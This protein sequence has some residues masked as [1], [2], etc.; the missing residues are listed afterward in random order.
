MAAGGKRGLSPEQWA[1]VRKSYEA[2]DS[3]AALSRRFKVD[4]KTIRLRRTREQ[5]IPQV[6]PQVGRAEIKEIHERTKAR[7]IDIGTRQAVEV[8]VKSGAVDE[9]ADSIASELRNTVLAARIAGEYAV[10]LLT[11]AHNGEITPASMPGEQTVADVF[12]SMMS[13]YKLF[14]STTREIAG[15][16]PGMPSLPS[17][18]DAAI[19]SIELYAVGPETAT[20]VG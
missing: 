15:L 12:K 13:G 18:D 20:E 7:V 4:R 9:I 5:W 10:K 11:Q 2:G 14:A 8:A 17:E 3:E 6:S 19:P 16:R 1:E